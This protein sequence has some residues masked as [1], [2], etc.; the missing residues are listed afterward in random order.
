MGI[1]LNFILHGQAADAIEAYAEAFGTK[2]DIL[3]RYADA[4]PADHAVV[5]EACRNRVYHA[6]MRILGQRAMF[7][8]ALDDEPLSLVGT[9]SAVALFDDGEGVLRTY[10]ALK[11][12]ARILYPLHMTTYSA[13]TAS[14]VDRFCVR[15]TLMT[16]QKPVYAIRTAN[17]RDARAVA[18]VVARAWGEAYRGML[19]EEVLAQQ[20]DPDVRFARID[21]HIDDPGHVTLLMEKSGVA[22]GMA[23]MFPLNGEDGAVELQAF[24]TLKSEWGGG[25]GRYLMEHAFARARAD[26]YRKMKL[27]VLKEN[28]RALAFYERCG[29][30]QTGEE[31]T[32]PYK[33]ADGVTDAGEVRYEREL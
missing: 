8:D 25:A 20:T 10:R 18:E 22:C 24:Y 28:A 19:C 32:I 9:L 15:W 6:E 11:G 17:R 16:E 5:S 21:A 12:G 1:S 27:W 7:S 26:G 33:A 29:F 14:L 30:A 4:T 31:S 3:L 13:C 23:G 2:P